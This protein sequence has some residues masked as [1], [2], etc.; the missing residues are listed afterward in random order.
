MRAVFLATTMMLATAAGAQADA[1]RDRFVRYFEGSLDGRP[2]QSVITTRQGSTTT[3]N[4]FIFVSRDH[5]MFKPVNP[6]NMPWTLTYRGAMYTSAD[7]G[8][9]WTKAHS[10]DPD[11]QHAQ[12]LAAIRAQTQSARDVVCGTETLDGDVHDTFEAHMTMEGSMRVEMHNRYWV[13]RATG[14]ATRTVSTSRFGGTEMETT[15]TWRPLGDA[16]LPVP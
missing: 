1:C 4:V 11:E 13:S 15:Q 9:S 12:A 7:Q 5:H 16:T 6:P 3:E 2:G 8:R 10:F 14:Q